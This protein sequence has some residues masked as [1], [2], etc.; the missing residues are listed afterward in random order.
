MGLNVLRRRRIMQATIELSR[1][2]RDRAGVSGRPDAERFHAFGAWGVAH[3]ES[4]S[5]SPAF[6]D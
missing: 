2:Q 4:G 6:E 3:G 5:Q 1:Q